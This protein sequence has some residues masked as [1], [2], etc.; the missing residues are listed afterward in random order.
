MSA[1]RHVRGA[2]ACGSDSAGVLVQY[3]EEPKGHPLGGSHNAVSG[4]DC[5]TAVENLCIVTARN[6]PNL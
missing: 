5:G 6:L 4:D 3:A 2:P 1:L